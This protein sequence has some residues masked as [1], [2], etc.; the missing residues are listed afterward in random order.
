MIPQLIVFARDD[1][2]DVLRLL[3]DILLHF[4]KRRRVSLLFSE[5]IL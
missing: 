5:I 1:R 4:G 2:V 3:I